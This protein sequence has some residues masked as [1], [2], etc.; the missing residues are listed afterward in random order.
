[1]G[2]VTARLPGR[3][4]LLARLDNVTRAKALKGCAEADSSCCACAFLSCSF[5]LGL[6][7]TTPALNA[8]FPSPSSFPPFPTTPQQNAQEFTEPKLCVSAFLTQEPGSV[9]RFPTARLIYSSLVLLEGLPHLPQTKA[10]TG[11]ILHFTTQFTDPFLLRD[12]M[13]HVPT[14]QHASSMISIALARPSRSDTF[15][16]NGTLCLAYLLHQDTRESSVCPSLH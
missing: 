3:S 8:P 9:L 15:V 11:Y 2:G 1:V 5:S 10:G 6:H 7:S 16:G 13:P 4:L 12:V 14:V